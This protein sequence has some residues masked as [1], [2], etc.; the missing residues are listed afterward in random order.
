M[1]IELLNKEKDKISFL[2]K[3]ITNSIVN[4]IRR[5]V[6]EIPVVAID[7][8]EFYKNDSAL[9]DEILAHRFGLIPIRAPKDF[10]MRQK[11]S[12]KGKGCVKC[13]AS[14]KLKAK[15][16]CTVY[17]SDLKAKAK[18][19]EIIYPK[20]PIVTLIK[21]QELVLTAEAALGTAK[22]HAKFNPGLLWFNSFPIVQ[23]KNCDGCGECIKICPKGA[24]SLKDKSLVI[25]SLKCDLCGACIDFSLKKNCKIKIEPS[26]N[27]FI[28][29]IESFGQ[30]KPEEILTEAINALNSNLDVFTK[31]IKK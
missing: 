31:K 29:F 18:A 11:C 12:C 28:F 20:M 30:L 8:V 27:D 26:K 23:L 1:K 25:D 7:T 9:Y 17:A 15:G 2:V 6:Y 19:V 4:A 21:D 16:P 10:I 22:Q 14:L 3:D 24:I 5:S 13:T